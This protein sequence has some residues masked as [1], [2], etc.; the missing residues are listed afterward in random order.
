MRAFSSGREEEISRRTQHVPIANSRLIVCDGS[1]F[2]SIAPIVATVGPPMLSILRAG[3]RFR[4]DRVLRLSMP[5]IAHLKPE[6]RP[7][8]FASAKG[9]HD[10]PV[11]A[12][13]RRPAPQAQQG[14]GEPGG[15]IVEQAVCR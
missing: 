5:A 2:R 14:T 3:V 6:V 10:Y 13:V 11:G 4:K 12:A 8:S 15:G 9:R 7:S 1:N